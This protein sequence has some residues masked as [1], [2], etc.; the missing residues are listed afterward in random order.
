MKIITTL[1]VF[2]ACATFALTTI[3]ITPN[4]ANAL[5]KKPSE[6]HPFNETAGWKKIDLRLREAWIDAMAKND[7][8]KYFECIMKAFHP[9]SKDEKEQLGGAGFKARNT[10]GAIATGRLMAKDLPEVAN[11]DFVQAMEL[12]VPMTLKPK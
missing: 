1:T 9:M 11:L 4:D 10:I 2:I 3:A 6:L 8:S 7:D 5:T 12:A